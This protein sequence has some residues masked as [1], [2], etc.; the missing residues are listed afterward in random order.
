MYWFWFLLF[1]ALKAISETDEISEKA[2]QALAKGDLE[3]A[4]SLYSKYMT[5]LDQH[6]APP[7]QDYYKIQQYIWKCIW[8]RFG[9]RVIRAKMPQAPTNDFDSV[10]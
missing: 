5:D 9:N 2:K 1:Q 8:M 6:L 10:D 3:Q 4:Q 7:Y